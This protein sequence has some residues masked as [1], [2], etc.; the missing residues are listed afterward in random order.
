MASP[1]PSNFSGYMK[2]KKLKEVGRPLIRLFSY[3]VR[4]F[5]LYNPIKYIINFTTRYIFDII[6]FDFT[7]KTLILF[8]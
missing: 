6:L 8:H 3:V 1:L 5:R 2:I 7:S 4:K